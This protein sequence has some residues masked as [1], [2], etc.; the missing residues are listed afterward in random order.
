MNGAPAPWTCVCD[1]VLWLGRGGSAATGALAPALHGARSLAV[2][3]AMVRYRETPVGP[4]DEVLGLVGSH[5]GLRPW[6]SVAFMAVDS[7]DSLVGGRINWA[8]PK[9]LATFEGEVAAGSTFTARG[10][11]AVPWQVTARSRVLGP[12][13][14]LGAAGVARQVFPEGGVGS[15]RLSA[16]ARVRAAVVTV[17]VASDG[18][19]TSWLRSG[20]HPGLVVQD[21]RF[22]LAE[23]SLVPVPPRCRGRGRR[24][25]RHE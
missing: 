21:A 22:T 6:G 8:L 19:L 3:G 13:V 4:Y 25:D 12:S 24:T 5:T 16:R 11:D 17:D 23:P 7:R 2:V 15:S 1:A 14:P 18:P 9:T 10:A 20:R